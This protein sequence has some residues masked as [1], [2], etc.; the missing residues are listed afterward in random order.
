MICLKPT[1]ESGAFDCPQCGWRLTAKGFLIPGMRNLADLFCEKCAG[2][3][4]GDLAAGQAIYTPI[5]LDKKNGAVFDDYQVEWFSGALA[6]SY[7]RRTDKPLRFETRKFSAIRN[8]VVVLN[9]LDYLYGH[10]L[11]KLLNAQHYLD[12]KPDFS[13]IVIAPPFLE[14]LLPV[15]IAEAWIVDLPLKR[16][17]EWNDWLANEI[18]ARLESFAEVFL[19][20]AFSHPHPADFDIERFT[21]VKPFALEKFAD[22]QANPV[23]TFIW[24]EDRL[25]E[26]NDGGAV[27]K[28]KRGFGFS[29]DKIAAQTEKIVRFAETLRA[30]FANLAFA[31]VG[32]GAIGKFP[33]WI[34]DLRLTELTAETEREWCER[35]AQ[36]HIV[37]G[38]HGSNMLLPSAHAG[39]TIEIIGAER[40]GNFLQDILPRGTDTRETMFRYRFVPPSSAPADLAQLAATMLRYEDFRRLMSAEFCR[41]QTK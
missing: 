19:S 12:E 3:F 27:G 21:K 41:H 16:G 24:R 14:W 40:Y 29:I 17:G 25:W 26:N 35:Y 32:L 11:L 22:I 36:S 13:L 10:S 31:V 37:I 5:L 20:V 34:A 18:A 39:A 15:G 6:D 9:C 30:R 7:K 4:Y 28:F 38:V 33:A 2:E 1:L 23:V 8:K